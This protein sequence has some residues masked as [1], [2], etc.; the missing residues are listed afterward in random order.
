MET[1]NI[2]KTHN[3]SGYPTVERAL[4]SATIYP[5]KAPKYALSVESLNSL[6]KMYKYNSLL[7]F[8]KIH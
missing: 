2:I 6:I 7:L 3:P 8:Q 1:D 5:V 4:K